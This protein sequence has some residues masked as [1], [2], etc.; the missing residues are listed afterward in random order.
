MKQGSYS[1]AQVANQIP[2]DVGIVGIRW[3]GEGEND[4]VL[5]LSVADWRGQLT[6]SWVSDLKIELDYG[7]YGGVIPAFDCE[8][9]QVEKAGWTVMFDLSPVG[10]VSLKCNELQLGVHKP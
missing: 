3:L 2:G 10:S 5:D 4:I 8:I 6:Y 9:T 7:K 1:G